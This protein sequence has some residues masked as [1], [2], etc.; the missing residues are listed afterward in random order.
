MN[1]IDMPVS[2]AITAASDTV[3]CSGNSV[4]LNATGVAGVTYQWFQNGLPIGA[5]TGPAYTAT[6]TGNYYVVESNSAGCSATSDTISVDVLPSPSSA[7]ITSG[8]TV[9]CLGD[10]VTLTSDAG[11]G[12]IYQWSVDGVPIPGATNQSFTADTAGTYVVN[13]T[14]SVGCTGV[15]IGFVVTV[16]PLPADSISITGS[17]YFCLGGSVTLNAPV[18]AGYTYQWY[19]A[20]AIIPGAVTATYNATAGGYYTVKIT[21]AAGCSAITPIADTITELTSVAV[22]PLTPT[23]FCWGSS[24]LLGIGIIGSSAGV[25]FQWDL[26]GLPITGATSSTYNAFLPGVYNCVLTVPS[27]ACVLP[28]NTVTVNEWPLP[29]PIITFSGGM[30]M[31][32][33]YFVTYQWYEDLAIIS[34]ATTYETRPTTDGNY[35][36]QVT[37]TNGCQS[38]SDTYVLTGALS[39]NTINSVDEDIKVYPNPSHGMVYI[40]SK[41]KLSGTL[42]NLEGKRVAE[43]NDASILDVSSFADGIY[44]LTLYDNTGNVVKIVQLVKTAN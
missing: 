12:I 11:P 26:N 31:T 38:M 13:D 36:V 29:D 10:S 6:S 8:P 16:N 15:S 41:V 33:T 2:A 17:P 4:V 39:V 44:L 24:A 34:G 18:G 5:A 35:V 43:Y 25:D 20:G 30:L 19:D 9:F 7:V 40:I 28:T 42:T 14:N 3:F 27:A 37:D 1:V 22:T 21:T 32:Q 23:S